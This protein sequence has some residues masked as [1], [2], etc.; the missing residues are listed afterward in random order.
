MKG[1]NVAIGT[2][3]RIRNEADSDV[4]TVCTQQEYTS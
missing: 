2:E 3:I 1:T 4:A